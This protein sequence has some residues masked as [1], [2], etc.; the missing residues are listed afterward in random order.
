[1]AYKPP[2]EKDRQAYL[3]RILALKTEELKQVLENAKRL[4]DMDWVIGPA[5][6][7]LRKRL[8]AA[9]N[10]IA[11]KTRSN[12]GGVSDGGVPVAIE[13]DKVRE[14]LIEVARKGEKISYGEVGAHFGRWPKVRHPLTRLL[15]LMFELEVLAG[16]PAL[17]VVVVDSKTRRCG[18]GFANKAKELGAA[19]INDATYEDEERERVYAHWRNPS[20]T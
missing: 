10:S 17:P 14:I 1:M 20:A 9:P 5:T 18:P 8:P 4:P 15:G 19:V 11:R 3:D 12:S 7:S 6:E 13:P 16:R 2:T